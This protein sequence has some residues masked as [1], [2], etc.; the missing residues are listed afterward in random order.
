MAW[1]NKA[2]LH[3]HEGP[4]KSSKNQIYPRFAINIRWIFQADCK[5]WDT[6]MKLFFQKFLLN[7]E[8]NNNDWMKRMRLTK[9]SKHVVWLWAGFGQVFLA[10]RF[11]GSFFDKTLGF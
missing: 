2:T 6:F 5:T 10:G 11:K 8:F 9:F 4:K 1:L 3:S 7:Q